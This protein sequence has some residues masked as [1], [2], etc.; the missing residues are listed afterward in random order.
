MSTL[1]DA[2]T[3]SAGSPVGPVAVQQTFDELGTPLRQATFVVVDLETTGGSAAAGSSITEIGAVKVRGGELLGEFQTLVAP[4]RPVP[5]MITTLTGISDRMLVDAPPPAAVIPSFLE[6]ARGSVLVAHNAG[7]DIGFLKAATA[8]LDLAWPR[9]PVVDTVL[10][11][12]ALLGRGETSNMRLATLARHFGS[13]T[14]P[15]HRAL[16][17]AL[18]IMRDL[19]ARDEWDAAQ[20]HASLR[21]YLNEEAHELDDAIRLGDDAYR[22][23]LCRP[24]GR[25]VR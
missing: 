3:S 22:P 25:S 10:M 13:P 7:F 17:D 18:A 16:D 12:R 11:A 1:L 4:G 14:T 23:Q 8:R 20:T 5:P 9:F 2:S 15:T 19:R 21:P 24:I 6:F